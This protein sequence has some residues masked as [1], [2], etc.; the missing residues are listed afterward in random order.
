MTAIKQ[1]QSQPPAPASIT[2]P[3]VAGRIG[4]DSSSTKS[5]DVG[6]MP[7]SPTNVPFPRPVKSLRIEKEPVAEV[8]SPVSALPPP[9]LREFIADPNTTAKVASVEPIKL[10]PKPA[11][12]LEPSTARSR[13]SPTITVARSRS[14]RM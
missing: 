2:R 6:A 12:D 9:P 1:A 5:S 11:V 13:W 8:A 10:A 3:E 7:A 14:R 4:P